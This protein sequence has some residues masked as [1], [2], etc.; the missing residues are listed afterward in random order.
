[1]NGNGSTLLPDGS[2]SA[3]SAALAGAPWRPYRTA[4][5]RALGLIALPAR[6]RPRRPSWA[7]TLTLHDA[8]GHCLV[9]AWRAEPM[10]GIRVCEV[11]GEHPAFARLWERFP[12][13]A[14]PAVH[15]GPW[16]IFRTHMPSVLY[17]NPRRTYRVASEH[18]PREAERV[19]LLALAGGIPDDDFRRLEQFLGAP[20]KRI[21]D[22]IPGEI[23]IGRSYPQY[24]PR[25]T[26]RGLPP[27]TE[28]VPATAGAP[29]PLAAPAAHAPHPDARDGGAE[30]TPPGRT[31]PAPIETAA[32]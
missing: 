29:V 30:S 11:V 27:M 18:K 14:G 8:R 9:E 12:G 23:Y 32:P 15:P 26:R 4:N 19:L 25:K 20:P 1:M 21:P 16:E 2:A 5:P 17:L 24:R 28:A 3:A 10:A 22:H 6:K 7:R 31:P 13:G